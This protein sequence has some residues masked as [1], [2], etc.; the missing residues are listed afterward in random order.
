MSNLEK[1]LRGQFQ[2]QYTKRILLR[3]KFNKR[4]TKVTLQ[5]LKTREIKEYLNEWK[6]T[7]C[8]WIV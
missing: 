2:L 4:R 3:N 8:L 7:P 5:K 6:D 1:E